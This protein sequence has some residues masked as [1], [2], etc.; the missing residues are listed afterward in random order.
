MSFNLEQLKKLKEA[1]A[2][3]V[4]KVKFGDNEVVYKS[5][6]EMRK[7]IEKLETEIQG[8]KKPILSTPHF[9]KGLN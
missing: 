9:T 2:T 8:A 7:T 1:Y 5:E 4:L 6:A 3:G